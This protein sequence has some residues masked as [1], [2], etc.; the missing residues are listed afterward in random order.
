MRTGP[1]HVWARPARSGRRSRSDLRGGGWRPASRYWSG[2]GPEWDVVATSLDGASLFLG[3]AKWHE[4]PVSEKELD[5]AYAGLIAKGQPRF[6]IAG[7]IK[8]TI[9]AIFVP[10]C[11]TDLKNHRKPYQVITAGD[12]IQ[13]LG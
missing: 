4:R 6:P 1:A 7:N 10:E 3:E 8:K 11:R 13:A 9:Y 12:V 2:S 5:K